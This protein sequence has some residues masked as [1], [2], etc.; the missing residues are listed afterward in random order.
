MIYDGINNILIEIN[1]FKFFTNYNT[2]LENLLLLLMG[3]LNLFFHVYIL[4][5]CFRHLVKNIIPQST[6][7]STGEDE[8]ELS[9]T[10]LETKHN[11]HHNEFL[12]HELLEVST[13]FFFY[14]FI[15]TEYSGNS[16]AVRKYIDIKIFTIHNF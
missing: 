9:G 11:T 4:Y 7:G 16:V 10:C 6:G 14:I 13:M 15:C 5:K 8:E 12:D 1:I 3:Q 2:K